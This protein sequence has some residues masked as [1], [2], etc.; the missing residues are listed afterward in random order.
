MAYNRKNKAKEFK[1]ILQIYTEVKQEDITDT[2]IVRV[3]FPK[4]GIY[5]SYRKWMSVKGLKPSELK[6]MED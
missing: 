6:E 5:I 3:V 2:Y 4:H 1:R